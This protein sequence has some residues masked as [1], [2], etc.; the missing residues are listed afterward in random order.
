MLTIVSMEFAVIITVICG[1]ADNMVQPIHNCC[2][3]V[4]DDIVVSKS[5]TII[6]MIIITITFAVDIVILI[7]IKTLLGLLFLSIKREKSIDIRGHYFMLRVTG[8][9]W[10]LSHQSWLKAE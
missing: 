1:A 5:D 10:S 7:S 2:V 8:V 6:N 4:M 9:S 3:V